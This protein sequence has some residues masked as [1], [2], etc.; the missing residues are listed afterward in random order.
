M[1]EIANTSSESCFD[2]LISECLFSGSDSVSDIIIFSQ[3]KMYFRLFAY[4]APN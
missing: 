4:E 2:F 1:V 3:D